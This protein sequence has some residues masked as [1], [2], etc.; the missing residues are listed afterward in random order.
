MDFISKPLH[1]LSLALSIGVAI[2]LSGCGSKEPAPPATPA[3][4]PAATAQAA[5]DAAQQA[6]AQPPQPL[7]ASTTT[8]TP[9]AM[10]ELLAP[11]ALY[12]DPV[13]GE[14][15]V[16]STNP[17]EVLDAGNWLLQNPGLEGKALDDA[18]K[19]V[20]FTPPVRGLLQSP[21]VIDMMCQEMGWTAELG[22]AFVNDQ[23]GV[24]DAVQRLRQ[25][26][27]SVGNLKS[28]PQMQVANEVQDGKEVV[29][30][31]PAS[32]GVVYVPQYDPVAV[33]AP[34]PATAVAPATT[35]TTTTTGHSTG[36]LVATGLLSFGA[37]ILV[38]NIFDDD[39]DDW[40]KK[41]Y[42]NPRYYGPPMPYYPPRPYYP[43]YGNGY[44]P[45][46]GYNRPPGYGGRNGNNY[47]NNGNVVI[48]TGGNSYWDHYDNNRSGYNGANRDG[49]SRKANSPITAA[50]PNR[51]ELNSLN[52]QAKAGPKRPAPGPDAWKGQSS[53]AG[54]QQGAKSKVPDARPG[55]APTG[56]RDVPK[57]QGTYAGGQSNA[58][59]ARSK[60]TSAAPAAKATAP[61][62]SRPDAKPSASAARPAASD[63]TNAAPSP[64]KVTKPASKP[65][66]MP[67]GAQERAKSATPS[68]AKSGGDRAMPT[69]P[70]AAPTKPKGTA[71]A[72]AKGAAPA[73]PSGV[74][75]KSPG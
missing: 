27:E 71:P 34:P 69:K 40:Y 2:A 70:A 12:P 68:G 17:Q 57:V 75:K 24:L 45:S 47:V 64:A 66:A 8:W 59:D 44:Y 25:Q 74:K 60:A 30:L 36:T 43:R 29:V 50:K 18:A 67:S 6:A 54:A 35:T 63:R 32:D 20:G 73:K 13:L 58:A 41:G 39:D 52:A 42:Y 61:N 55:A 72:K 11:V 28:S 16:A 21:E 4:P 33:Y 48:N 15:L 19:E 49:Q 7:Q 38:A 1:G 3:T 14:V 5:P 22:Q 62:V 31:K 56:T 51:P 37:G 26:A 9:E 23:A 46:N 10:E 65:A 53:Y